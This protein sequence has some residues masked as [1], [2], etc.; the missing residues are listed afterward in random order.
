M[1]K[2]KSGQG[3]IEYLVII[4]VVIVLAL[5]VVGL[6]T[7][8]FGDSANQVMGNIDGLTPNTGGIVIEDSVVDTQGDALVSLQNNT[9]DTITITRISSGTN[10]NSFDND[11]PSTDSRVFSLTDLNTSCPCSAGETTKKC[12][13]TIEY[14]TAFGLTKSASIQITTQCVVDSTPTNPGPVVGLGD[15]TL[16]NPWMINTCSELQNMS[17]H[18]DGNYALGGDIDCTATSSWNSGEGF[19]PVGI[20]DDWTDSFHGSLAGNG[21]KISGLKINRPSS[22]T[23]GLFGYLYGN[24]SKLGFEDVNVIGLSNTGALFGFSRYSNISEVYSKGNVRSNSY[25]GGIGGI[26]EGGTTVTDSYS[27]ADVYVVTSVSGGLFA[28]MSGGDAHLLRAYSSGDVLGGIYRAG[29]VAEFFDSEIRHVFTTS[30]LAG[31]T[32]YR[33]GVF[34]SLNFNLGTEN[35]HWL[36]TGASGCYVS[37]TTSEPDCTSHA[38]GSYFTDMAN[39]PMSSFGG[40]GASKTWSVC[41]GSLPHLTWENKTC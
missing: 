24:V 10:T 4:A 41:S 27:D 3:T 39:A 40:F 26:L 32:Q 19:I 1:F 37:K 34:E 28:R 2:S 13:F 21:H 20:S 18:L 17:A 8:I 35:L 15:G 25:A 36:E 16:A 29:V 38:L 9:G 33:G 12:I 7:G 31:S 11:I 6:L 14:V 23:V 5:V 30:S 22:N